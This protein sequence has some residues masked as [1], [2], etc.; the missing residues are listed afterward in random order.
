MRVGKFLIGYFRAS[1]LSQ[2]Q[3]RLH[4][5]SKPQLFLTLNAHQNL[6]EDLWKKIQNLGPVSRY[7]ELWIE[8]TYVYFESFS[9][10]FFCL[11]MMANHCYKSKQ[12]YNRKCNANSMG[13]VAR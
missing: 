6:D 8:P 12:N 11:V 3:R 4:S 9:S 7:A 1:D 10:D 2:C 13:P 5:C